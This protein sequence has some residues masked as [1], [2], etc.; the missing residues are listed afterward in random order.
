VKASYCSTL[1]AYISVCTRSSQCPENMREGDCRSGGA[2]S[3]VR[4]CVV[5]CLWGGVYY[6]ASGEGVHECIA[7]Y[8]YW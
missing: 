5:V 3:R 2:S 6:T 4:V 7:H 1:S 8:K